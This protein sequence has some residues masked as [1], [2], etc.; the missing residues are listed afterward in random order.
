MKM[1]ETR[2]RSVTNCYELLTQATNLRADAMLLRSS[3]S[4][5]H[6]MVL[7]ISDYYT[8]R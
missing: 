6:S 7:L 2:L 8:A 1:S 4:V 5:F 3:G